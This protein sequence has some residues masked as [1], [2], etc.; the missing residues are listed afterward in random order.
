MIVSS[1]E[2]M[3]PSRRTT[4]E[5]CFVH[6]DAGQWNC[7]NPNLAYLGIYDGHGGRE[8]V[9]YLSTSLHSNIATELNQPETTPLHTRIESAFLITDVESHL[10]GIKSSGATVAVSLVERVGNKVIIHAANCGD[11]RIVLSRDSKRLTMD[12]KADDST[13]IKRIEDSG[14]FVLRNR[15]LGIMAV[16]RSLG[17]HCMKEFVIGKP[18]I[19]S[20]EFDIIEE[21]EGKVNEDNCGEF[22]IIACDGLWDCVSDEEAV[23]LVKTFVMEGHS[24]HDENSMKDRKRKVANFLAN[25]ALDKGSTGTYYN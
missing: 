9:D 16:S 4:M 13:E 17:D 6:F 8:T 19:T 15:V 21:D 20:T 24:S 11:A 22:I 14:G 7:N 23:A 1:A 12:H 2:E 25:V 18:H 10:A 3:N 5:D